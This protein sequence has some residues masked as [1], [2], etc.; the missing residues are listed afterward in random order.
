ME[1]DIQSLKNYLNIFEESAKSTFEKSKL[2]IIRQEAH[3][4]I[5]RYGYIMS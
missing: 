1:E 2:K 5:E 4:E 3:I